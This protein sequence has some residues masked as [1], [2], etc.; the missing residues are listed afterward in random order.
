MREVVLR[1]PASALE[2]VLDRLLPTVP[3]GVREVPAGEGEVELFMR[4]DGLPSLAEI[5]AAAD[6]TPYEISERQVSD[7]WRE[8]RLAD[9]RPEVI[10]ERLVVRPDWAPVA[11]PGLI[12][13]SLTDVGA[14]GEGAHPTTRGCLELLL[15]LE[16]AGSFADLGCGSGVLAILAARLG[17]DPVVAVDLLPASVEAARANAEH[18]RVSIEVDLADLASESVPAVDAFAANVPSEIHQVIAAGGAGGAR[19]VL[20]S[21]FGAD[22]ADAVIGTYAIAGLCERRRAQRSGWVLCELVRSP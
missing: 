1:V 9:Y 7:D 18:N 11:A 2:D 13:I 16:P 15:G 5:V 6:P 4:G 12:D 8:R 14:F 19:S 17:W 10:G 22:R 20:V 21:G 3:G